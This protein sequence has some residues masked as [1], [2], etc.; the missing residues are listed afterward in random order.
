M[1]GATESGPEKVDE[2]TV[3]PLHMLLDAVETCIS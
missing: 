2:A 1:W 3:S